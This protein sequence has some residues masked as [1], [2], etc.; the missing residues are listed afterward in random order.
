M[1]MRPVANTIAK[2]VIALGAMMALPALADWWDGDRHWQVFAVLGCAVALLGVLVVIATR[3]AADRGMSIRQGFLLTAG[4]WLVL[5]GFGALPFMLGEPG[6]GLT[7]AVFESMSGIT[8]TGTTTIAALD[9]LPAGINLWRALLQWMGG[10][11]I[12]V[13]AV[14]FLPAMRVGG[15]QFFRAEGFEM[16]GKELPRAT[17]I[18]AEMTKVYVVLTVVCAMVYQALGMTPF[19]A[20]VHALATTSSGGFS[21]YDASFG[22]YPGAAQYAAAVFLF[23]ATTPFIRMGQALRGELRPILHD[24]QI[25]AYFRWTVYAILIILAYRLPYRGE[26]DPADVLRETVFNTVVFFSGTGFTSSDV[27][28]WGNLPFAVLIVV[29]LIGGCTGST[30][31]SVKVFR[32]QVLFEAVRAQIRR[33]HSPHRV[34][35]V[36]MDGRPL[37]RDVIDS[38]MGFF[39]L[40]VLSFGVLIVGLALTGLHP[41]TALTA[42]W[43]SITNIGP[44]WGPEITATGAVTRLPEA[45]KWLMVVGMYLGRLELIAVFVLLMPRFWRG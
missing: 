43:T 33:M 30:G 25:R 26:A 44:V 36:R 7:D 4:T 31:C 19:D 12:V 14:A 32:Y 22:H 41:L 39:T 29:G 27:T 35:P 24:S 13:V 21:N 18:A 3:G 15:M 8:T 6:L 16:G 34:Y 1:M 38:V 17:D 9:G 2:L 40:F 45:A 10:L 20:V 11:G 37:T 28:A 23:L 42:A 5:P